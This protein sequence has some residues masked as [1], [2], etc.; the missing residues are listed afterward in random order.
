MTVQATQTT[1]ELLTMVRS[2]HLTAPAFFVAEE[3]Q[4]RMTHEWE[5]A[6]FDG[7][8]AQGVCT[9]RVLASHADEELVSIEASYLVVYSN[10]QSLGG[11]VAAVDFLRKVGRMAVY[12]YFRAYVSFVSAE[13]QLNVPM[14]PTLNIGAFDDGD[15]LHLDWARGG[16]SGK[17][18]DDKGTPSA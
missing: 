14:L 16:V 1:L 18:S 8:D 17:R 7:E 15:G 11:E 4:L 6:E 9:F 3:L 13:A 5:H 12:P 2:H 10:A